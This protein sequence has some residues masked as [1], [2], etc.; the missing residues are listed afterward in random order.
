MSS[1]GLKIRGPEINFDSEEQRELIEEAAKCRG[2]SPT[3]FIRSSAL[4]AA[5]EVLNQSRLLMVSDRDWS[6]LTQLIDT[7]PRPNAALKK[8]LKP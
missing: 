3:A 1:S 8:L 6:I 4:K 5:S 7:P 2:L